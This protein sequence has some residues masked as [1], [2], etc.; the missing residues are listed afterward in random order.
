[1]SVE[2]TCFRGTRRSRTRV[3]QGR[4]KC[5][6]S[7]VTADAARGLAGWLIGNDKRSP[8]ARR[9]RDIVGPLPAHRPDTK[10]RW[11]GR[12]VLYVAQSAERCDTTSGYFFCYF[13]HSVG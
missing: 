10:R 12:S 1:M 11:P 6:L 7:R 8:V 9:F 3:V 5:P 2:K 4:C 13:S